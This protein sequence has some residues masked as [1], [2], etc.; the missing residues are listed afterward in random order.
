MDKQDRM[1]VT[2]LSGSWVALG[3]AWHLDKGFDVVIDMF[4]G[5]VYVSY[6]L[7]QLFF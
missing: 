3:M 1:L 5:W 4:L 2:S 6:K 7:T